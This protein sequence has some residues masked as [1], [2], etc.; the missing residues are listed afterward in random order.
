MAGK[1]DSGSFHT[2]QE[3]S[4]RQA[5]AAFGGGSSRP[6]QLPG[7]GEPAQATGIPGE[8]R[9]WGRTMRR[10]AF[11]AVGL[12]VVAAVGL[13]I[14]AVVDSV[15]DSVK[16]TTSGPDVSV[17]SL[18]GVPS[19]PSAPRPEAPAEPS[20]PRDLFTS[21]GLRA[22]TAKARSLAGSG[23]RIRLARISSDQLQLVTVDKV[24]VVSPA[25]T[26]TITTPAGVSTGNEFGF[27]SLN[28][29]VAG[30]LSRAIRRRYGVKEIDYMVVLRDPIGKRVEWLAYP[31]GGGA[32]FEANARGGGLRRVG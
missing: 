10:L 17:P 2:T 8:P 26:R 22:A 28:P 9:R 20:T 3:E 30:R 32:H 5:E 6:P 27:A 1:E 24:V 16:K 25:L 11:A 14:Y 21:S 18:P 29:A 7:V 15:S 23:A 13:G 12:V 31:V 4:V 19:I